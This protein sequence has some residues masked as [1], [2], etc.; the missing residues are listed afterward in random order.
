MSALLT[1]EEVAAELRMS[2]QVVLRWHRQGRIKAELLIGRSP[3][4]DLR[5]VRKQIVAANK[6]KARE[7]FN[8]MVPTL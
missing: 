1:A 3:R 2:W 8:G 4:F 5:K 7:K 6:K